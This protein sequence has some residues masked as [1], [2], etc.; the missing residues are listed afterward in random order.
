MVKRLGRCWLVV[1]DFQAVM[2]SLDV[3]KE[4]EY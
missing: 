2:A 3:L 1:V 4:S